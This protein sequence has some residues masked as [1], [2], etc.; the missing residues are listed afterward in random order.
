MKRFSALIRSLPV[1]LAV[2]AFAAVAEAQNVNAYQTMIQQK[3]ATIQ[4]WQTEASWQIALLVMACVAGI[5]VGVLQGLAKSWTKLATVALGALIAG[6]TG[7]KPIVFSADYRVLQN[8]AI[9]A[10]RVVTRLEHMLTQLDPTQTPENI[11]AA[12]L[13]L[14]RDEKHRAAVQGKLAKV[15]AS[16]GQPG[17][18][19]R[20]AE[21]IV[22]LF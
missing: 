6:V 12:A 17:A 4:K 18:P 19:S 8:S 1:V 9:R 13:E 14:L 16:L 11:A 20:A 7:L 2:I 10:N 22:S 3:M 21:A 15:I 5:L